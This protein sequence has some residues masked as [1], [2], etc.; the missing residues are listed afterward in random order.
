VVLIAGGRDKKTD[1]AE[2]VA[3]VKLH[4]AHVVLIGEAAERFADDLKT[5][6]YAN[7]TF[8][9]SLE[10]AVAKAAALAS[11]ETPVLFSPA[12]AS[13]DMFK[14][15]EERGQAF[16]AAVKNLLTVSAR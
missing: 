16:K 9:S 3:S 4:A 12:C 15:F 13:F 1:L 10:D 8:A 6:G 14:N 2:F 7:I 5:S 11:T